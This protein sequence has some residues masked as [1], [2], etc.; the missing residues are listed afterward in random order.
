M[1]AAHYA[2]LSRIPLT[3]AGTWFV[4]QGGTHGRSIAA[5]IIVLAMISDVADGR[6]AR[7]FGTVSD[8]GAILDLTTDKIF[9]LPMLF[10]AS[11]ADVGLLW[12]VVLIAMRDLLIMGVRVYAA[13]ESLV[14]PARR[15]GK[16]K[17]LLAYPAL[18]LIVLGIPHAGWVLALATVMAFVSGV[19]Y[20]RGAWPL[21][22]RGLFPLPPMSVR[23]Q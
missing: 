2:G 10:V 21:L 7:R 14:I 4:L 22:S 12:M 15:L 17:S 5:A 11:R 23:R 13:A 16:L 8:F 18:L 9:V 20:V 6:L 3:I 1:T 19:D